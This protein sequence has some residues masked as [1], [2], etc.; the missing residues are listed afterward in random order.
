MNDII[1]T[2]KPMRGD[3]VLGDLNT[4]RIVFATHESMMKEEGSIYR[5]FVA[6]G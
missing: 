3:A 4:K 2:Q 5:S 6:N 1:I